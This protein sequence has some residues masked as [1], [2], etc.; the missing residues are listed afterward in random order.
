MDGLAVYFT[1]QH[2]FYQ[3]GSIPLVEMFQE[4]KKGLTNE[5]RIVEEQHNFTRAR[6]Y[7]RGNKKILVPELFPLSNEHLTFME[8]VHGEKIA[9]AFPGDA[10][11]RSIM[12][13]RLSDALTFEVIFSPNEEALFHGDPHAGN[14]YH[15]SGDPTD[16]YRI[17]LLDWGLCGLFPRKERQELVQLLLGVQLRDPRRLRNNIDA[18]LEKGMPRSPEQLQ[19]I[20]AL[21][22]E[23]LK[24]KTWRSNFDALGELLIGLIKEGRATKSNLNLFIKS[25]I[26]IAGVLAELDPNLK[27]DEY[28]QQRVSRLVR[29]EFPKRLVYTLWFPAWNSHSYRSMLSNQDVKDELFKKPKV[30]DNAKVAPIQSATPAMSTVQR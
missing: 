7:Y 21:I 28:V 19:R 2:D 3:L 15:V 20:D 23:V 8:F 13:R 9:N 1:G 25:Q 24:P 14:V 4:I 27:Q 5:I 12:A 26:T 17:A 6:A 30:A 29:K 10:K 11:Q 16:P 22:A 18:L